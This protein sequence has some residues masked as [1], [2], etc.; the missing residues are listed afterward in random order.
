MMLWQYK[1]ILQEA[2]TVYWIKELKDEEVNHEDVL[3]TA[4]FVW[5]SARLWMPETELAVRSWS[6]KSVVQPILARLAMPVAA[7][8]VPVALGYMASAAIGGGQG[9]RNFHAF[10]TEPEKMPER[11]KEGLVA[12]NT[13]VLKPF[14]NS[15]RKQLDREFEVLGE[16]VEN[17]AKRALQQYR[18][19]TL[20]T[21]RPGLL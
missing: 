11:T 1:V 2:M 15:I 20:I 10:I 8:L 4:S 21:G 13:H 19:T 5:G 6:L 14:E 17:T 18:Y 3:A 7:V 12:L 16:Y 9:V